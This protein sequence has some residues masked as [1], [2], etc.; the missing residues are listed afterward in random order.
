LS[1]YEYNPIETEALPLLTSNL[2]SHV[3]R[4]FKGNEKTPN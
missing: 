2:F 4:G 1:N 3:Q